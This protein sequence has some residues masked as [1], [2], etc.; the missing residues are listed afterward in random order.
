MHKRIGFVALALVVLSV[1]GTGLAYN[2]NTL[3]LGGSR[4]FNG[5]N[6][7]QIY[8]SS[9]SQCFSKKIPHLFD[10]YYEIGTST[11]F[12]S[13]K[14]L[15]SIEISPVVRYE[16]QSEGLEKFFLEAGIGGAY[17]SNRELASQYIGSHFQFRDMIGFGRFLD[18]KRNTFMRVRYVHYSNADLADK[19]DGIDSLVLLF[20]FSL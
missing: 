1:P 6:G 14:N 10:V 5:H 2:N 13:D 12:L 7:I 4:L 18:K 17:I 19:N 16:F 11:W 9:Y 3:M 8:Y 20:G 15:Y